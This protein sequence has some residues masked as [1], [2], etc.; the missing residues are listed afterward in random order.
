MIELCEKF[1]AQIEPAIDFPF[2]LYSKVVKTLKCR[3]HQTNHVNLRN[4]LHADF[5]ISHVVVILGR[6]FVNSII[7]LRSSV[8]AA[9]IGQRWF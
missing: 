4:T 8:F 9:V 6:D 2:N 7:S 3:K 5:M 1:S